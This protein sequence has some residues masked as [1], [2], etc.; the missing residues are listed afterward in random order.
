LYRHVKKLVVANV[1]RSI[2]ERR[3]R[4]VTEAVY[5]IVAHGADID[6]RDLS[7]R[8]PSDHLRYFTTFVATLLADFA[9]YLE[10]TS[11]DL[12]RDGIGYRQVPLN[13]S[14]AEFREFAAALNGAIVP[15]LSHGPARNRTRRMF[16]AIVMPSD[17]SHT[18]R[19]DER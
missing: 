8:T 7:Q 18:N 13:L 11:I 12:G 2:E 14:D 6:P 5:Q 10:R 19:E 9:R 17:R 4:S 15:F 3:V 1:I 16:T